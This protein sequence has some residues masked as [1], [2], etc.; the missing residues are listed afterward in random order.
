LQLSLLFDVF[1]PPYN[2]APSTLPVMGSSIWSPLDHRQ[3]HVLCGDADF[4]SIDVFA[5][6]GGAYL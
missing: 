6:P 4:G 2:T 3:Q 1:A 5:Y